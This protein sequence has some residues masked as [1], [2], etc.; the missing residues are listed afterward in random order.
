M[1]WIIAIPAGALALYFLV[2]A[3]RS[4]MRWE[5]EKEL[6]RRYGGD[7]PP[8]TEIRKLKP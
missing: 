8:K 2:G 6:H 7:A 5:D 1:I 3:F 4:H